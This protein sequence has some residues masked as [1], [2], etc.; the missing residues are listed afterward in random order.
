MKKIILILILS[1]L[2]LSSCS[3]EE[4]NLKI[5]KKDFFINVK[6]IGDFDNIAYLNKT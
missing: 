5:E 1:F 3:K 4:E 6:K 2:T